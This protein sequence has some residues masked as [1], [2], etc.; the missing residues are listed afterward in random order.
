MLARDVA[1]AAATLFRHQDPARRLFKET[2]NMKPRMPQLAAAALLAA[3]IPTV[4]LAQAQETKSEPRTRAER[5]SPDARASLQD[6]RM[7]MIKETL[8]LNDA[9]LKLW[10]P[11]EAQMRGAATA[12]QQ[13]RAER[14]QLQQQGAQRPGLPDRLDRASQRMAKRAE[15]MKAFADAFRPFYAALSDDQKALAGVVLRQGRG[16]HGR[17]SRG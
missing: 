11:V 12:R 10:A 17:R 14:E 9:Q 1:A 2:T 16:E 5:L 3:A 4:A 15:Q 13:A 6:G 8:K 7:A